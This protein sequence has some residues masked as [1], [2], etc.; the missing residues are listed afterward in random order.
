MA[1][2][3]FCKL[4]GVVTGPLKPSELRALAEAGK[5]APEDL[6]RQG[7]TGPW[8]PARHVRGLFSS[9]GQEGATPASPS[10]SS[11]AERG[12]A[13]SE[14]ALPTGAAQVPRPTAAAQGPLPTA[15]TQG[16]GQT[17]G[18]PTAIP[19]PGAHIPTAVAQ[20]AVQPPG[21]RTT[22]ATPGAQ[23]T[24][25]PPGVQPSMPPPGVQPSVPPPGAQT[26]MAT[27][28]VQATVPTPA[29]QATGQ[30]LPGSAEKSRRPLLQARRLAEPPP[31][32]RARPDSVRS[33]AASGQANPPGPSPPP[34][35]DL[36]LPGVPS[37]VVS[38]SAESGR[39]GQP[40]PAAVLRQQ[41]RLQNNLLMIGALGMVA[42]VLLVVVIL[43]L[44]GVISMGPGTT[45]PA[46][47]KGAE[48]VKP[49][50][51][52]ASKEPAENV[53]VSWVDA[54]KKA[55]RR[56]GASVRVLS[57]R[58]GQPPAA[59]VSAPGE[60]LLVEMQVKNPTEDKVLMFRGWCRGG[61]EGSRAKLTDNKGNTYVQVL[62]AAPMD[63]QEGESLNRV[64]PG[65]TETETL[66]FQSPPK[67]EEVEYFRLELPGWA[68]PKDKMDPFRFQIPG[69]MIRTGEEPPG[70][71]GKTEEL[72]GPT[73]PSAE[74]PKPPAAKENAK[75]EPSPVPMPKKD[76]AREEFERLQK[77]LE[78][79]EQMPP[80]PKAEKSPGATEK[81]PPSESSASEQDKPEEP[82]K[83]P[84]PAKPSKPSGPRL[85][86]QDIMDQ[87]DTPVP[88]KA[89]SEEK[90]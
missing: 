73:P 19:T 89:S 87:L 57:V 75:P 26:P 7:E 49:A 12:P 43:M 84:S 9:G 50:A 71:V 24:I 3:W 20:A 25:P 68:F 17:G 78:E 5:L 29:L 56:A 79:Q 64:L 61:P 70:R 80:S 2:M 59:W 88:P 86:G 1:E 44:T 77:E 33:E 48:A 51:Q 46:R 39:P 60:Y 55:I 53:E 63:G 21:A 81:L 40:I 62:P 18:L 8:V 82:A 85:P 6:V 45:Q 36:G 15:G 31:L 58:V 34:E 35:V 10:G 23:S 67:I 22:M 72:F 90:K 41:R 42:L 66:V 28:G 4:A 76:Q 52:A 27:P 13:Q 32:P 65:H 30:E 38:R 37:G 47:K 11:P 69:K 74:E 14:Q 54:S 16:T 83:E